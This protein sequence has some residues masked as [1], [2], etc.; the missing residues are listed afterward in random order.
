MYSSWKERLSEH[1]NASKETFR[2]SDLEIKDFDQPLRGVFWYLKVKST[3]RRS[4]SWARV[5]EIYTPFHL[6]SSYIEKI[7][8]LSYHF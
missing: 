1:K 3:T 8:G 6:N 7:K 4:I 2:R 5:T